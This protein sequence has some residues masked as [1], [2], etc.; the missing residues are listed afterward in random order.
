MTPA[1]QV[2]QSPDLTLRLARLFGTSA[3]VW[4]NGQLAWKLYH[5]MHAPAVAGID[6]I[7]PLSPTV[8]EDE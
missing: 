3:G 2:F 5:A 1:L 8:P 6:D 4:L 7:V